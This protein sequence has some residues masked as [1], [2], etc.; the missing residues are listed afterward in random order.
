MDEV[1]TDQPV[2]HPETKS[3]HGA[4]A[5]AMLSPDSES[6][7]GSEELSESETQPTLSQ[8]L[9]VVHKCTAS[10]NSVK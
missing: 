5:E 4:A 8:I 10:V 2:I 1:N 3:D 7:F 6:L 9:H